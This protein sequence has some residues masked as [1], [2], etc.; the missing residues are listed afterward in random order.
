MEIKEYITEVVDN[1]FEAVIELQKKHCNG[2]EVLQPIVSPGIITKDSTCA[3]GRRTHSVSRIDFDI[4][5]E[6]SEQNAE[7]KKGH[8]S[9]KVFGGNIGH[10]QE[11]KTSAIQRVSFSINVVYPSVK[12]NSLSTFFIA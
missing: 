8:L 9:I 2:M 5:V 3:D 1:I 6:V 4:A 10:E 7:N 12:T 11:Y